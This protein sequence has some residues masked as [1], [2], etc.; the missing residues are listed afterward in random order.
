MKKALFI[1]LSAYLAF[2]L[3]ACTSNKC[4]DCEALGI[5][6]PEYE[7]SFS[8]KRVTLDSDYI[9]EGHSFTMSFSSME[10]AEFKIASCIL[11]EERPPYIYKGAD[12]YMTQQVIMSD[13]SSMTYPF[14]VMKEIS[15]FNVIDSDDGQVRFYGWHHIDGGNGYNPYLM[16]QYRDKKGVIHVIKNEN[17]GNSNISS[18]DEYIMY[19]EKVYSFDDNGEKYYV[20]LGFYGCNIGTCSY[21]L[22]A[23]KMDDKGLHSVHLFKDAGLKQNVNMSFCYSEWEDEIF[24]GDESGFVYFDKSN[25]TFYIPEIVYF[26]S[27]SYYY[28]GCDKL[29]DRYY[30]YIWDGKAFALDDDNTCANPFLYAK[31]SK[32]TRIEQFLRTSRNNVRIDLMQDGTY[33]YV[34]WKAGQTMAEKPELII[35]GGSYYSGVYVFHNEGYIYHVDAEGIK[36]TKSGK[37]VG[38][39]E[40]YYE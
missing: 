6:I 3:F 27:N 7:D 14:S 12:F 40:S 33:R 8:R 16:V 1:T 29:T 23:F 5:T 11:G 24:A 36:I 21:G 25:K 19:P 9:M 17:I 28:T 20:L 13:K 10:E 35:L 15:D 18:E 32:Y 26:D 22:I 39:W 37:V 34:A 30:K 31:L 2:V 38:E 4:D